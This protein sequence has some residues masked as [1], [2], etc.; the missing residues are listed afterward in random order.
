[1]MNVDGEVK[2]AASNENPCQF[3][4]NFP[5]RL[6]MID[7]VVAKHYIKTLIR[8]RQ[9]LTNRCYRLCAALPAWKQASI[10]N[11][12]RIDT[13]S[14]LSSKVEDESMCSTADLN[15]TSISFDRLKLLELLAHAHRGSYHRRDDLLFPSLNVLRLVLL[16][17]ELAL[18]RSLSKSSARRLS[19]HHVL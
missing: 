5:R 3:A 1:M 10:T 14:V 13:D 15:H 9:R 8:D 11:R 2:Q 17:G 12:E 19:P 16:I 7:H 18:E 4:D 6:G